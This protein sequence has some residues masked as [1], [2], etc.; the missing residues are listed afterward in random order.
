MGCI[1]SLESGAL[2]ELCNEVEVGVSLRRR[3]AANR[4]VCICL[5][6]RRC[7]VGLWLE[8]I[9]TQLFCF[10]IFE[11]GNWSGKSLLLQ[12]LSFVFP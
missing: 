9:R 4:R 3:W 5:K 2:V 8:W 12:A 10:G 11:S 1:N 6:A 7:G